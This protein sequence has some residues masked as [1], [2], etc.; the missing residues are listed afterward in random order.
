PL[1]GHVGQTLALVSRDGDDAQVRRI[2]D[3][4]ITIAIA[5]VTGTAPRSGERSWTAPDVAV[6]TI[7]PAKVRRVPVALEPDVFRA[8]QALPGVSSPNAY[9]SQLL[10]RGGSGDQNL[11]LLDGY[12][13]IHPYHLGGGF[14]AFH[15]DAIRDAEFW[16]GAPPARYGG[17]LSSVLDIALRDG[18]RERRTGTVSVSPVSSAAVVEGPHGRG[19]WFVG[20]RATY[21]DLLTSG[22]RTAGINENE[23]PYRFVD[24][25]AKSYAD[26]TP[27]DR[28]SALVFLG[29]DAAWRAG[30]GLED[31]QWSNGV[32]GVSWRHL[33]RGR[34][35]FEQRLSY[36]G[37]SENL[38]NGLSNLQ[39]ARLNTKH[40]LAVGSVRGDLR[41]DLPG[42]HQVEAGYALEHHYGSHHNEYFYGESGRAVS[43][44]DA[45]AGKWV[46]AVYV[47]DDVTVS[48]ALR[49]RL[50]ARG[51]LDGIGGSVQPRVSARYL[52]SDRVAVTAGAGVVLQRT[53]VIQDPD[54]NLSTYAVDIW[55]SSDGAEVPVARASHV[56]GGVEVRLP[57]AL[58]LRA[59][60]YDKR[61]SGVVTVPPYAPTDRRF[62]FD[63]MQFA[64]GNARGVD[65]FLG[66]ETEG[67]VR[68]WVGYSLASSTR[69]A[70]AYTFP[71]DA[72][73]RHR[74]VAVGEADAGRRW[75]L[76]GRFEVF[77]GIPYTP[78]ESSIVGRVM[79][80]DQGR[81]SDLCYASKVEFL[82]GMRN[83]ARTGASRR[84][85]LGAARRW[86]D[87]RGRN[88]ELTLSLLNALF[89]PTGVFR[90]VSRG[91]LDTGTISRGCQAP[92]PVE[93]E[94]ELLFPAIPSV[95]VR[96][97][98]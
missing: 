17:R 46:G 59:E 61:F 64:G 15:V 27:S 66:R 90:P 83:S 30:G 88:W 86:T 25:Y 24:L 52:F 23:V 75:S 80:L 44:R 51:E 32:L 29:H 81:I 98:F 68:G 20:A 91:E 37:F 93:R 45:R 78:A 1:G 54:V 62:S 40:R 39:L 4:R 56:V 73:P 48:D 60:A 19:A 3:R 41:A 5:G 22:L 42:R 74:V 31:F 12:P 50:G 13:V 8:I 14:S 36:S 53:Q 33:L 77:E 92:V 16:T 76:S 47:Q 26:V 43:R 49:L 28:L 71:A 10:V 55:L 89:D 69:T 38:R 7:T 72:H 35:V 96:V 65:L 21:F 97:T 85:D 18:N 58:R 9:S 2:D 6:T 94:Q 11:F 87:R 57:G 34:A 63:R 67:P 79:D 84:L 70:D 95:G 82:Y